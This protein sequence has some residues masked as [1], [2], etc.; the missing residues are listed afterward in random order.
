M[1][2]AKEI[3]RLNG[4]LINKHFNHNQQYLHQLKGSGADD[5]VYGSNGVYSASG[6]TISQGFSRT[7]F[8]V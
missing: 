6:Q 8:S 1:E 3:N 5:G 4:Q 7:T 2:Q